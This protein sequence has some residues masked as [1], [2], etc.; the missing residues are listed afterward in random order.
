[1]LRI[2]IKIHKKILRSVN[3]I[4]AKDLINGGI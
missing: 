3:T 2:C 4:E 1:M